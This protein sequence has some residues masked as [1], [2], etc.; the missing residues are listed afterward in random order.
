MRTIDLTATHGMFAGTDVAGAGMLSKVLAL[1]GAGFLLVA[2]GPAAAETAAVAEPAATTTVTGAG[3]LPLDAFF[4]K[5][6]ISAPELSPSG[7]YVAFVRAHGEGQAV[8]VRDRTTGDEKVITY[9]SSETVGFD[10]VDWKS[11]DR[12][13]L[14]VWL[15]EVNRA[16][17]KA[18][19][20]IWSVRYGHYLELMDRDGKNPVAAFQNNASGVSKSATRLRILSGLKSDP[21]NVLVMAPDGRGALSVWKVDIKTGVASLVETGDWYTIGWSVDA[22]GKVVQRTQV[23]GKG[24]AFEARKPDGG[25][26]EVVRIRASDVKELPDFEI[27]GPATKP[28]QLYVAVK[29]DQA[30]QGDTRTLRIYDFATRT[31]G[32]PEW[33][34]LKYD[35]SNIVYNDSSRE[36]AGVCYVADVFTC[37]FKDKTTQAQFRSLNAHFKDNNLY[38]VSFS[39]DR[40]LWVVSVRGAKDPGSYYVYEPAKKRL[41]PMGERYPGLPA[42]KLG[43]MQRFVFK[44]RDGVEIPAYVTRPP[45]AAGGPLPMVVMPHGGPEA[46]DAL[47]YDALAQFLTTRGYL[48]YQPN[49][50]GSGGYGRSFAEAGYRQWGKRMQEDVL[51]GA[52]ALI[53]SGQADGERVCIAGAS[54]GGYAALQAGATEPAMFKCV[55]SMFGLSDLNA[56]MKWTRDQDGADGP[57]YRYWLRNIGDPATD[58]ALLEKASPVTYAADYKPP[59]LLIH[60]ELDEIVP[61]EQSKFMDKALKK[62]GRPVKFVTYREAGHGG[63]NDDD[64][65]AMFTEIETFLG[66]HIGAK[67]PSPKPA[68]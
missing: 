53:A 17:G 63:L 42:A 29:P 12:L 10:W 61:I 52:K 37:D 47:D 4:A 54:Y 27:L 6:E 57:G 15:F 9:S 21:G 16:N 51:D 18:K 26:Q 24:I 35:I 5:P 40:S 11:D 66:E 7:R 65:K 28:G 58:R 8:V 22:L 45:G 60:G 36:L 62:A 64:G 30:G 14:R 68:P 46:R 41:D 31:L 67:A 25:W 55:I 49:F 38:P 20:K 56:M 50:R 1:A 2:G 13:L 39:D 23:R 43:A 59:V 19:G 48:V 44:A 3:P 33:G 32:P 34:P